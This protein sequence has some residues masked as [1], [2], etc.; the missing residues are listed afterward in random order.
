[1]IDTESAQRDI[2]VN[3]DSGL[4][5]LLGRLRC[6]TARSTCAIGDNFVICIGVA[7][8]TVGTQV[9]GRE[10]GQVAVGVYPLT[11]RSGISV[12]F[13]VSIGDAV[14]LSIAII[15]KLPGSAS[16]IVDFGD[17]PSGVLY[18]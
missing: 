9:G 4:G 13:A 14:Q 3:I 10:L 11:E 18:Y 17:L 16:G 6:R 1:L 8:S 7:V 15:A 2:V 5:N 12:R